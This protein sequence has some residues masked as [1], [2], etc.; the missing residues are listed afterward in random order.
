MRSV[1]SSVMISGNLAFNRAGVSASDIGM[2]QARAT[3]TT[4]AGQTCGSKSCLWKNLGGQAASNGYWARWQNGF[5]YRSTDWTNAF[6][7]NLGGLSAV[8]QAALAGYEIRYVIHRMCER[9]W[10]AD[11]EPNDGNPVTSNCVADVVSFSGGTNKGALDYSNNLQQLGQDSST[12]F[13]RVTIRVRG[14]RNT[15]SYAQVWMI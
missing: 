7:A 5:D 1:D 8:Q 10:T 13:Y 4:I 3:I 6:V 9:A 11:S 15:L 14:P 2:E 12:P